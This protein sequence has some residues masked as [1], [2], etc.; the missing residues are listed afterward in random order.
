MSKNLPKVSIIIPYKEDRGWLDDALKSVYT[1]TYQGKIE[2]IIAKSNNSVSFNLNDGIKRATGDYIKYL[3]EDDLLTPNS[4]A[5][6]INCM[7]D[8]DFINGKAEKFFQDGN[9]VLFTP[10]ILTPNLEQ[11]A[12]VNTINGGTL[13]YKKSVFNKV[14]LFDETLDCAEEY[15]FNL[16]CLSFGLRLGYC[17]SILY[18]Y[19]RHNTQKSLGNGVNQKVRILKIEAIQNKYKV[20]L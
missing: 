6:S 17:D 13:M 2:V 16:R 1:Q 15:E 5:D 9:V 10:P 14:G 12:Q 4:I 20:L 3:C 7:G 18:R 11:L 19:R 8:Y